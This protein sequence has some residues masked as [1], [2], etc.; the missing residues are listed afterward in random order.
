M[1]VSQ[2]GT[3]KLLGHHSPQQ[4]RTT[5]V[6][7]LCFA[8]VS[9]SLSRTAYCK[10]SS[11]VV[12]TE[13]IQDKGR[14]PNGVLTGPGVP[15]F[16]TRDDL[17]KVIEGEHNFTRGVELGVQRGLYSKTILSQWTSCKEYHL[18]DIWA[19]QEN[20]EDIANVN[21]GKQNE[22]YDSAMKNVAQ[23]KEKIHVCRKYTTHCAL[24]Y[25]D[26]YFD[27]IY[28]DARHDF[29]GVYFKAYRQQFSQTIFI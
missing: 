1:K 17:G 19:H 3:L 14:C 9:V 23:W 25:D 27:F 7:I 12:I 22:I 28:V 24:L 26:D 21:Q 4:F 16:M 5:V 15:T 2:R 13:L 11:S 10:Q 29:K 18:V 6:I 20:Y 8:M